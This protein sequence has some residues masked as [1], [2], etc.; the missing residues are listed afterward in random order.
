MEVQ[1]DQKFTY[2][3]KLLK[4]H[5]LLLQF[6]VFYCRNNVPYSLHRKPVPEIDDS[7]IK[8]Y[9]LQQH[10]LII[11]FLSCFYRNLYAEDISGRKKIYYGMTEKSS[12]KILFFV[13]IKMKTKRTK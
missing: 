4:V 12:K 11:F 6:N 13:L 5:P 3:H 1:F 10:F 9:S 2:F 7:Y 8:L